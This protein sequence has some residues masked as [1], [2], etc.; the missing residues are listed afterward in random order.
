MAEIFKEAFVKALTPIIVI[1][2]ATGTALL[3]LYMIGSVISAQQAERL[4]N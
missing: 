3:P 1:V 4:S 2:F